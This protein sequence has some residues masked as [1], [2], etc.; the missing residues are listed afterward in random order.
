MHVFHFVE[1]REDIL[2]DSWYEAPQLRLLARG[3]G[4][5]FES[6]TQHR[7]P[8]RFS[9]LQFVTLRVHRIKKYRIEVPLPGNALGCIA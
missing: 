8:A 4:P 3:V 1:S 5:G 7:V 2:E 6:S 9:F